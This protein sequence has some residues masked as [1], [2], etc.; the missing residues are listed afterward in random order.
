MLS[1][2]AISALMGLSLTSCGTASKEDGNTLVATQ[3][4]LNQDKPVENSEGLFAN[5]KTNKGLIVIK[6]EFEK[7]PM[8]VANFVG[9]AEGKV[10][11]TA[12]GEGVPYYDGLKFHRVIPDFMI[13]GGDPNGTGSGGP[14]YAFADEIHPDLKHS[15]GGTLSMANAGPATNGSQFFITHKATDWLDGKHTVFGYVTEGMD[16]V[17]TIAGNDVIETIT[18]VRKGKAAEAF[19]VMAVLAANK[20][21]FGPSRR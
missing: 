19:D 2:I 14:G 13:Q 11:N 7:A 1:T 18:I 4:E 12:K 16:V 6:L 21:K 17:N 3:T 10:K 8:T 5:I 9:L 15:R 20:D